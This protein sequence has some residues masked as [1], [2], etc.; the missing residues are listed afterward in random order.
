MLNIGRRPTVDVANAQLSIE[1]HIIDFEG[2]IYGKEINVEF[3]KFI[4]EE[5]PF[6]SL[7]ALIEQLTLDRQEAM[8]WFFNPQFLILFLQ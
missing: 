2:D 5:R 4:R 7:D 8:E 3:V 6:P 1:A